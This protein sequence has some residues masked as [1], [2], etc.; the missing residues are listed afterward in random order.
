MEEAK[1]ELNNMGKLH[2]NRL[3]ILLPQNY[4]L[5]DL[6]AYNE[7]KLEIK[8][9]EKKLFIYYSKRHNSFKLELTVKCPKQKVLEHFCNAQ[10]EKLWNKAVNESYVKWGISS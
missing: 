5:N 6:N 9:P 1:N 7:F 2:K 8:M 3:K 10:N 4:N